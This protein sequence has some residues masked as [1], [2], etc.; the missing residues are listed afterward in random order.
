MFSEPKASFAKI[1]GR[2]LD[3]M[4]VG[5]IHFNIAISTR[6]IDIQLL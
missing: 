6:Q 5:N 4:V 3:V 1:S 2:N